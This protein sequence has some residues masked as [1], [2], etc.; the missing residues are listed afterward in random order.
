[1]NFK[2]VSRLPNWG[3]ESFASGTQGYKDYGTQKSLNYLMSSLVAFLL[4]LIA[5]LELGFMYMYSIDSNS[6][7]F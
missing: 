7:A 6:D 5:A 3:F 4:Q 1:M 2:L